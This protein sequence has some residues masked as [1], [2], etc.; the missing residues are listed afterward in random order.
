MFFFARIYSIKYILFTFILHN[1]F[2]NKNVDIQTCLE[3]VNELKISWLIK[4]KMRK[5]NVMPTTFFVCCMCTAALLE[6]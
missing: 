4:Y 6:F 5:K 1:N 3:F 2:Q